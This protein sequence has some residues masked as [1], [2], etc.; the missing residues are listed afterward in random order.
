MIIILKDKG[1]IVPDEE[2]KYLED[3]KSFFKCDIEGFKEI[4]Y[5]EFVRI[6][7][8][9]M[10]FSGDLINMPNGNTIQLTPGES[11]KEEKPRRKKSKLTNNTLSN[12]ID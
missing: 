1:I 10:L 7:S 12:K 2:V 6:L 5:D 11:D 9:S 4:E 8:A 3:V